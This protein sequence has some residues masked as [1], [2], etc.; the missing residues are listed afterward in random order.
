MLRDAPGARLRL[1]IPRYEVGER[2]AGGAVYYTMKEIDGRSL[3]DTP[4][5][6]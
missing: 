6:C 5:G 1:L 4:T 3:R 2:G